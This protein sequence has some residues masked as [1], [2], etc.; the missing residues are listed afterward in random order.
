MT[1]FTILGLMF[2]I[3]TNVIHNE[4]K[5]LM[6][7]LAHL[8][9]ENRLLEYEFQKATRLDRIEAMARDSLGMVLPTKIHYIQAELIPE[10]KYTIDD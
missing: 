7:M 1:V 8:K 5:Q 4:S 6:T 3:K 2:N 9:E 10:S